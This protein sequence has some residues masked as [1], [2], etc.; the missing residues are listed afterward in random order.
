MDNPQ[1]PA[2]FI[3]DPSVGSTV[4]HGG[5]SAVGS[6][7]SRAAAKEKMRAAARQIEADKLLV[8]KQ[9]PLMMEDG[10]Q[11]FESMMK[12]RRQEA[13][14]K[15]RD[16][17]RK[18]ED[19][20]QARKRAE[21]NGMKR[22]EKNGMK[23][24]DAEREPLYGDSSDEEDDVKIDLM[25]GERKVSVRFMLPMDLISGDSDEPVGKQ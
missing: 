8:E 25:S 6:K 18:I 9:L 24:L 16:D 17:A 7:Q 19:Q 23:S 5:A 14:L 20:A 4:S 22:A 15:I 13:K 3:P 21:K 1:Q 10:K 11:K 2:G 12:T